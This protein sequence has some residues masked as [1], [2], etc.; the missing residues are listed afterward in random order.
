MRVL[1]KASSSFKNI[2][3]INGIAGAIMGIPIDAIMGQKTNAM[4]IREIGEGFGSY[5][6]TEVN[7]QLNSIIGFAAGGQIPS[8][9]PYDIKSK[10]IGKRIGANISMAF[11]AALT[12]RI[13][14]ILGELRMQSG[15]KGSNQT[16]P[17]GPPLTPEDIESST[18]IFEGSGAERV[19]NFFKGKGLS[20]V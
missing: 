1:E 10:N 14:E 3:S 9:N 13:N 4:V 6:E 18:E 19:W 17:P 2:S 15:K 5:I 12:F 20:V 11:A 16:S 8:V 7:K